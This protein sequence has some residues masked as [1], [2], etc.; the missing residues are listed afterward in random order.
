MYMDL[1][2]QETMQ[3]FQFIKIMLKIMLIIIDVTARQQYTY[4]KADKADAGGITLKI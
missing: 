1:Y 3:Y 2:A 4:K